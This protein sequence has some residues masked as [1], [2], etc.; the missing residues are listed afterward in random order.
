MP[1]ISNVRRQ[2]MRNAQPSA[3]SA[4]RFDRS[5]TK[6][7]PKQLRQFSQEVGPS[8]ALEGLASGSR[9]ASTVSQ[10]RAVFRASP[11]GVRFSARTFPLPP[12]PLGTPGALRRCGALVGS[13]L[14][15][16]SVKPPR[17]LYSALRLLAARF[18]ACQPPNPS[19]ERDAQELSL[20]VAPHVTR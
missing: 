3:S 16:P 4:L 6:S 13:Q 17:V 20:L 8:L 12:C 18:R 9:K 11:S 10:P 19:I 7:A 5:R 1:L 2:K 15:K 14:D